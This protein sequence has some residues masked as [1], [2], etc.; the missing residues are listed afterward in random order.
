[1]YSLPQNQKRRPKSSYIDSQNPSSSYGSEFGTEF[2]SGGK[3][4]GS[5]RPESSDVQQTRA[6]GSKGK[7][8][9]KKKPRI[10]DIIMDDD[11]R[12]DKGGDGASSGK[13]KF[14]NIFSMQK[15]APSGSAR[16]K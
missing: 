11:D 2:K 8:K 5:R 10:P 3:K 1:M 9:K 7:K 15:R 13:P 4:T 12:G 14:R 6:L 16:G